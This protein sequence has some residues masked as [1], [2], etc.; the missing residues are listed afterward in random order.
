VGSFRLIAGSSSPSAFAG[1]F[2]FMLHSSGVLLEPIPLCFWAECTYRAVWHFQFTFSNFSHLSLPINPTVAP[3]SA[4]L[5]VVS[6]RSLVDISSFLFCLR[7]V[8]RVCLHGML[9]SP[10]EYYHSWVIYVRIQIVGFI[11]SLARKY[12]LGFIV[13]LARSFIMGF[14]QYLARKIQMGFI[15]ILARKLSVGF[16]N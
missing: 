4:T 12:S 9:I 3:S 2:P 11:I 13:Y 10:H 5:T 16:I 6:S 14:I 7:F 15:F 1:W 8:L